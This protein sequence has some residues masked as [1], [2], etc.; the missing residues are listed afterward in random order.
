MLPLS[1][2]DLA[3]GDDMGYAKRYETV[4]DRGADLD[5]G[6]MAIKVTRREAL[7]EQF[8]TMH[9]CLNAAS[10]VISS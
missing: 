7:T 8:H 10:T 9:F 3:Y 2:T 6:N 4:Q 1:Q 5:L